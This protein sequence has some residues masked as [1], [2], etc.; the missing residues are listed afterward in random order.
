LFAGTIREN[1]CLGRFFS[2]RKIEQ[3]CKTA[4]AHEFINTLDKG[5]DTMLGPSGVSLSGGQKQRIA[6]ARAIITDPR[7][8][9]HDEATSALD[10][11]SE[12]I[13]QEALDNVTHGRSTIVVAHRLSTIE[14]VD[15]V[16]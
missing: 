12:R 9:L 8:L 13:V 5:I 10:T 7:L 1:I 4:N 14:N 3:A 15:Q 6:I 16:I 11:Q 2:D